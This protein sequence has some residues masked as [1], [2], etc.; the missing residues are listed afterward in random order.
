MIEACACDSYLETTGFD[1]LWLAPSVAGLPPLSNSQTETSELRPK[2]RDPVDTCYALMRSAAGRQED[3]T[4]DIGGRL[5]PADRTRQNAS[6]GSRVASA[7]ESR[8]TCK[9]ARSSR[10]R[11]PLGWH[12]HGRPTQSFHFGIPSR[13][14]I[15][16]FRIP[17]FW[18]FSRFR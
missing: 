5:L 15:G 9:R 12:F 1:D 2:I 3:V 8:N 10:S 11:W 18:S 17:P 4:M 7:G 6:H 13:T 14:S 16:G